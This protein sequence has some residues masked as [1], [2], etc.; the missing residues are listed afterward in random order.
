MGVATGVVIGVASRTPTIQNSWIRPW[1]RTFYPQYLRRSVSQD[2]W[3]CKTCH[4]TL[5][6]GKMPA[7][8]KGNNLG[9]ADIPPEL[10]DLNEL[11]T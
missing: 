8:A 5:K 9:L 7:Q 3:I 1:T 11:E 6:Q 10:S 2:M 4:L